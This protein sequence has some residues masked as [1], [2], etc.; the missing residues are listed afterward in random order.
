MPNE[1]EI[2]I[3]RD[4][5]RYFVAHANPPA[6]NSSTSEQWWMEAVDSYDALCDRHHDHPLIDVLLLAI[7]NYLETKSKEVHE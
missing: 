2:Q 6:A 1:Q 5:Y 4:A 7:Y 3:F